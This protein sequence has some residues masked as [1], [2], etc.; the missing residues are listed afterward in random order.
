M[1]KKDSSENRSETRV[2]LEAMLAAFEAGKFTSPNL[3][4]K[5]GIPKRDFKDMPDDTIYATL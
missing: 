4:K 1:F 2:R 3:D 5:N